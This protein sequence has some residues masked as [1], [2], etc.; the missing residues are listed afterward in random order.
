MVGLTEPNYLNGQCFYPKVEWC[1][2]GDG[3]VDSFERV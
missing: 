2:E 1:P 3:K